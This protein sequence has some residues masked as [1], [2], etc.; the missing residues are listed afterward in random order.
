MQLLHC[1]VIV[2]L[3]SLFSTIALAQTPV[4]NL[5]KNPDINW[6]AE[7]YTYYAP[8]V[9]SR[10]LG[11]KEMKRLYHIEER[12]SV[13]LLK[14]VDILS[15]DNLFG[16][17]K[18]LATFVLNLDASKVKIYTDA[19]LKNTYTAQEYQKKKSSIDTIITFDPKTYEELVQVVVRAINEDQLEVFK[20]KQLI[21][22]NNK[23]KQLGSMPIAIAPMLTV[24]NKKGEVEK[25]TA[26]FW[27]SINA[28]EASLD[29]NKSI[30]DY[31]I[32]MTRS[33]SEK[34]MKVVKGKGTL[35]DV[36]K[37]M[38]TYA[39]QNPKKV[40]LYQ[41]IGYM[42][43]MTEEEVANFGSSVDTIITFDPKTFEEIVQVVTDK[44]D[45]KDVCSLGL[46]QDWVW[47]AKEQQ[48]NIRL[49]AYAP[50]KHQKDKFI[51]EGRFIP[52][53]YK[54]AGE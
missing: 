40:K 23:T 42:E 35:G 50:I 43:A 51:P 44:F 22:Y 54:K 29:L 5:L 32:R 37:D 24:R 7:A 46:V 39:T 25:H 17:S 36:V 13:R 9:N 8:T 41:N 21:Y 53:F 19:D 27:L 45:P 30:Y 3:F 26:V 33:I 16:G 1:I 48:L 49:I 18:G 38:V 6:V 28:L 11:K 14:L 4:Q 52:L 47:D 15:D 2:S 34:E 10:D 20:I 12:N 31:A